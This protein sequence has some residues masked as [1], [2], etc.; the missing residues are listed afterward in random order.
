MKHLWLILAL[1][2]LLAGCAGPAETTPA[3]PADSQT[4]ATATLLSLTPTFTAV[5][6]ETP[7]PPPEATPIVLPPMP[8]EFPGLALPTLRGEH[9]SGSGNCTLCH[10]QMAAQDGSDI[11]IDFYWKATM[12]ANS[13]RDP[14]W[15]A[16]VRAETIANPE[17][18]AL[19]Q[20]TCTRCH[21]PMARTTDAFAGGAG[22]VLD[23]G[24]GDPEHPLHPLAI[25]GTSC[26]LCHQIEAELLGDHASFDGGYVIDPELPEGER[27]S[28]GPYQVPPG[29]ANVMQMSSG[30]IPVQ[31]LHLQSSEVCATCH[32]LYTPILDA[33]G[34]VIGYFPEQMPYLEWQASAY[35]GEQSCQDCHMPEV[36][37]G[38]RLSITGS[39]PRG[40]FSQHSFV[41]GNTYALTLMRYFGPDMGVTAPS[42]AFE[43]ALQR[44][45]LQL[46]E[47]TARLSLSSP[48]LEN[49]LLQVEV[50]VENLV[51][52]KFPSSFPSRRA[53]LH[54]K[55]QDA[56]GAV[57]FESG[58]WAA[59]G[60]IVG[61][62]NDGDPA[63]YEP[64]YALIDNPEQVQIYEP[65]LR[66]SDGDVTTTLL[67]A[68]GYL[69]DNRL[70]PVGFAKSNVPQD[71][72]VFGVAAEDADF[73][74][75]QDTVQYHVDVSAAQGPFTITVELFYQS[76]GYRWAQNLDR[77]DAAETQQFM[78]YYR[79]LPNIPELVAGATATVGE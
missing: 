63:S 76:I 55:V 72:A 2:G 1:L 78:A 37:G 13:G 39:P 52:H 8:P 62:D 31:G 58:N 70:L 27:W 20:D 33:Q 25:D 7:L 69:K 51:G 60:S 66:T 15:L 68:A 36:P 61:N 56:S 19:I 6:T 53:W 28:Y 45:R 29:Q 42:A 49:D 64:H 44:A 24:Y 5:P 47:Q 73:Q 59:D 40:P 77:Y 75:G 35:A 71:V 57:I 67:R 54:F 65:I 50:L 48:V 79:A 9:F 12:M 11:S 26:N 30:Y 18:A 22:V 32:T 14:Y 43:A 41:G 34:Q 16:S 23:D 38:V 46:Q 10:Q 4:P 17:I 3:L 21:M 74:G